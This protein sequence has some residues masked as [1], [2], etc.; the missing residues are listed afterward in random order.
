MHSS[1]RLAM[2]SSNPG[3]L[4]GGRGAGCGTLGPRG[5]PGRRGARCGRPTRSRARRLPRESRSG[6]GASRLVLENLRYG[7]RDTGATADFAFVLAGLVGVFG[8]LAGAGFA[9]PRWRKVDARAAGLRQPDRDRLLW[10]FRPML[11]AADLMD[12]LADEFA[13]L[14]GRRLAGT[15][16]PARLLD[17]SFVWHGLLPVASTYGRSAHPLARLCAS[18]SPKVNARPDDLIPD[19]G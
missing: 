8:A 4:S 11:S 12:F 1:T 16:V 9:A 18:V 10:R 3:A 15:L 5:L 13:R 7:A 19:C 2:T 6:S 14:R 17:R